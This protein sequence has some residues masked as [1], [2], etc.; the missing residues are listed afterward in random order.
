[1]SGRKVRSRDS[2]A[3]DDDGRVG[4]DPPRAPDDAITSSSSSNGMSKK[5]N[6][7]KSVRGVN[8]FWPGPCGLVKQ[9]VVSTG[10]LGAESV[11][12]GGKT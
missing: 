3:G 6:P 4:A 8:G 1:M 9:C 10:K 11:A 7:S 2:A 5:L 12:E